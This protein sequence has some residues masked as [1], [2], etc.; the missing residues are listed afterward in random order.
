MTSEGLGFLNICLASGN[1]FFNSLAPANQA[2]FPKNARLG[3]MT[4]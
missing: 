2:T 3:Q 4:M 1:S